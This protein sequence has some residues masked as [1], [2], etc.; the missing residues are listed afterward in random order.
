MIEVLTIDVVDLAQQQTGTLE[1]EAYNV[2][3]GR[4]SCTVVSTGLMRVEGASVLMLKGLTSAPRAGGSLYW[5]SHHCGERPECYGMT[6]SGTHPGFPSAPA[7]RAKPEKAAGEII[8]CVCMA[9]AEKQSTMGELSQIISINMSDVPFFHFGGSIKQPLVPRFRP[10]ELLYIN[11]RQPL[12]ST[13]SD[14]MTPAFLTR[15]SYRFKRSLLWPESL[16]SSKSPTSELYH[17][18]TKGERKA[19]KI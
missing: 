16:K 11:F 3:I 2:L 9:P 15:C 5:E 8:V 18:D 14:E 19:L 6:V 4:M 12:V 13:A 10:T 7:V 17:C 1:V